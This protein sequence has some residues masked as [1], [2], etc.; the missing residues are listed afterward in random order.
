MVPGMGTI[1]RCNLGVVG[2]RRLEPGP[3]ESKIEVDRVLIGKLEIKTVKKV[4]LIAVVVEHPKFGTIEKA[5]C[6]QSAGGDEISPFLLPVS[7][8]QSAVGTA[9]RP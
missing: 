7:E 9:A 2:I 1:R 3:A 4:F 5:A 6:I 8:I